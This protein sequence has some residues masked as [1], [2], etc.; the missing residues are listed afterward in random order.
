[1]EITNETIQKIL[2]FTYKPELAELAESPYNGLE[3]L[4]LCRGNIQYCLSVMNRLEWETPETL[5]I[6]DRVFGEILEIEDQ[7]VMTNGKE[8][9]VKIE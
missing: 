3:I 7:Y 5:V 1:M 4:N 2:G 8:I 9:E 6:Q